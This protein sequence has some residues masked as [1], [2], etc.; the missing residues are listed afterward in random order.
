MPFGVVSYPLTSKSIG[1]PSVRRPGASIEQAERW[2]PS[3]RTV[4]Y[5]VR[6]AGVHIS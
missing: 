2:P 6:V 5:A 1:T 4:Y 3:S